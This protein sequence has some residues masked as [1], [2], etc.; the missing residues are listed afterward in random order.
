M[1]TLATVGAAWLVWATARLEARS[2]PVSERYR[3]HV[4][5]EV[6]HQPEGDSP[7]EMNASIDYYSVRDAI[8]SREWVG[9]DE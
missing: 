2:G 4:L 8:L 1:F 7:S 9:M 5:S 6:R 3:H